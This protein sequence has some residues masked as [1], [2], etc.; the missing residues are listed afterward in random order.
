LW[1]GVIVGF[2][3]IGPRVLNVPRVFIFLG[4]CMQQ[5]G[6]RFEKTRIPYLITIFSCMPIFLFIYF[7]PVNADSQFYQDVENFIDQNLFGRVGMWSSVFP[8]PSKVITNYVCLVAPVLSLFFTWSTMK[9]STFKTTDYPASPVRLIA[10]MLCWVLLIMFLS[11]VFIVDETNLA[12]DGR[13]FGYFG[14][15]RILYAFWS[16]AI[17]Y[18]AC[19]MTLVS[20]MIFRFF[21]WL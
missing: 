1:I 7:V 18:G 21:L 3:G 8:L 16:S 19:V 9:H 4:G 6:I 5:H 13:R 20:Y 15:Y 11:Y 2:L 17:L 10:L 12:S 14:R